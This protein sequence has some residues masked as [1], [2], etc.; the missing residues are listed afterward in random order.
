MKGT[1]CV[2]DD[3]GIYRCRAW[4]SG[5]AAREWCVAAQT[6][7]N[8]LHGRTTPPHGM[9]FRYADGE[10]VRRIK[11]ARGKPVIATCGC[12][13]ETRYASIVEASAAIGIAPS[14][15]C[16]CLRG[17]YALAGGR[18]WRYDKGGKGER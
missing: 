1:A 7:S 4:G 6:M 10:V 18:R 12:G 13:N 17:K 14:T 3:E 16:M 11:G 2:K 5:D 8:Y 9:L 15:I